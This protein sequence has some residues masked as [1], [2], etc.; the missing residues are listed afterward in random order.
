[1]AVYACF[2]RKG[3]LSR[4]GNKRYNAILSGILKSDVTFQTRN[5]KN[6]EVPYAHF[7]I[8]YD[9]GDKTGAN[10][11]DR[12]P[13]KDAKVE[14]WRDSA[15]IASN[16]EKGDIVVVFGI[17]EL[18]DY[19]TKKYNEK[20]YKITADA[21]FVPQMQIVA[22]TAHATASHP[23]KKSSAPAHEQEFEDLGLDDIDSIF[24]DTSL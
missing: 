10:P 14:C 19:M 1:M 4:E 6:E 17:F 7:Y 16:L 8:K 12:L 22:M 24:P 11:N 2:E 18:D 21:L 23:Q 3:E 5:V 15:T 13:T 20:K 9:T